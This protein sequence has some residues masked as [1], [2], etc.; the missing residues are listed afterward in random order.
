MARRSPAQ[1]LG[2]LP[3]SVQFARGRLH[4]G[5]GG[6]LGDAGAGE[7]VLMAPRRVGL[8]LLV[9]L[10]SRQLYLFGRLARL[11]C[12]QAPFLRWPTVFSGCPP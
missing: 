8:A 10:E 7:F 5:G 4:P 6:L 11:H 9:G 3:D 2:Q 12:V 1:L